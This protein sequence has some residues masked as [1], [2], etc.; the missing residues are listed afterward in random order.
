MV[1]SGGVAFKREIFLN[2]PLKINILYKIPWEVWFR[3]FSFLFM[4]DFYREMFQET[5]LN[6]TTTTNIEDKPVEG[7][8][9][10]IEVPHTHMIN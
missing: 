8:W 7:T 3:S 9:R 2:T 5:V 1:K 10:Y 4:G 6:S